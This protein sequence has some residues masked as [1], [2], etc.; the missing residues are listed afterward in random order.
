MIYTGM[1]GSKKELAARVVKTIKEAGGEM[2]E[3]Q[4]I[5]KLESEGNSRENIEEV[6]RI[7]RRNGEIYESKPGY[8]KIIS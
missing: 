3:E 2:E 4:L 7:L 1:P 8:I 5:S 6:L